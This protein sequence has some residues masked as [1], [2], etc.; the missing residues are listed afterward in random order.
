MPALLELAYT[1]TIRD[2]LAWNLDRWQSESYFHLF[3]CVC[4]IGLD[5]RDITLQEW[6]KLDIEFDEEDTSETYGKT[7]RETNPKTGSSRPL[8]PRSR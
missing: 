2:A 5:V 4:A 3:E 8:C 6:E 1:S 7:V